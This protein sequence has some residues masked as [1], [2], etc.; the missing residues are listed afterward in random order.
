MLLAGLLHASWHSLVKGSADQTVNL[1]G[2]GMVASVGA[3]A[4]IPFVPLP[5]PAAWVVLA[6][7][8]GLHVAYKLCVAIAYAHGDLGEAFPL[9]RGAVPLFATAIAFMTLGQIPSAAQC[10][11]IALVSAGLLLIAAPRLRGAFNG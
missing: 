5:A 6:G 8:V 7:S 1:V 3:L 9:S 2:M 4:V 11:G 10:A